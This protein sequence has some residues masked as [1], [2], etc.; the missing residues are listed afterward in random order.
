MKRWPAPEQIEAVL[1]EYPPEMVHELADEAFDVLTPLQLTCLLAS[2]VLRRPR[3]IKM[4]VEEGLNMRD[5]T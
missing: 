3:I 1:N 4:R 5:S 2:A